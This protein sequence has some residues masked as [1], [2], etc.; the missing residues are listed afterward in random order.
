MSEQILVP[1]EGDGA[2]VGELTWGQRNIWIPIRRHHSSLPIGVPRKLAA[3]VTIG[4]VAAQLT[5]LVSRHQA[6]RTRVEFGPAADRDARQVL[7]PSGELSVEI[8]DSGIAGHDPLRAAEAVRRRYRET[9]FDYPKEWP[10]RCAV[11]THQGA[12]SY[13]V[14]VF[15]H[16]SIDGFG[17]MAM[18]IDLLRRGEDRIGMAAHLAAQGIASSATG[19]GDPGTPPLE[20]ARWQASPAG[21][22]VSDRALWHW[23]RLM[24]SVPARRVTDGADP[25]EP[26][27]WIATSK[28]PAARLAVR[29]I[30]GRLQLRTST[31]LFAAYAVAFA[32]AIGS[33]PVLVQ[34]ALSNRL[35]PG[36]AG[37]VSVVAQ[38]GLAV[39]DVADATFDQ[40]VRD[41]WRATVTASRHSYYDPYGQQALIDTMAKRR[42]EQMEVRCYFNDRRAQ[43][44]PEAIGPP[45]TPD[46]LTEALART[47]LGWETTQPSEPF[48]VNVEN[49]LDTIA[50]SVIFD[51]NYMSPGRVETFLHEMESILVSAAFDPACAIPKLVHRGWPAG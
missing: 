45:P 29:A 25:R 27:F 8:V 34:I 28:S 17:V 51:T 50:W 21:Q 24:S 46:E 39:I 18:L 48:F 49:V 9:E 41:A 3:G 23:E 40:V 14:T 36:L 31:V 35:R 11:I 5:L 19:G 26:R 12:P 2:G 37:S 15:C 4:D 22:R 38:M 16:L 30:A 6:L 32:R 43:I 47:T 20:Q 10:L 44:G 33:N 13:L 7:S 1:F 42:A